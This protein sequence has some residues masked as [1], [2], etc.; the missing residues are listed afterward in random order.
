[1][2]C[3]WVHLLLLL[4]NWVCFLSSLVKLFIFVIV[5]LC[6][7]FFYS[8]LLFYFFINV[9]I[10]FHS[11]F[12]WFCLL[13]H[14]DYMASL[15]ASLRCLFWILCQVTC[16]YL[17]HWGHLLKPYNFLYWSHVCL[18]LCD[19]CSFVLVSVYLKEQ[20]PLLVFTDWF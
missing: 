3:H 18:T 20:T 7:R 9:L 13:V 11:L 1:M 16:R 17:F 6:Y 5:C 8:F 15:W 2:A 12:S 10:Y 14:L 4:Q 19:L